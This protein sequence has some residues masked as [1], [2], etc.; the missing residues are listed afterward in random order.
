[1]FLSQEEVKW[2]SCGASNLS[3]ERKYQL[4]TGQRPRPF[5][6]GW[7][8]ARRAG[9]SNSLIYMVGAGEQVEA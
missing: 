2:K 5:V 3:L 7:Y 4:P 9:K 6:L 1:M 8:L